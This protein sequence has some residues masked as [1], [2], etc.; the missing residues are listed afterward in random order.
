MSQ[1]L[2]PAEVRR[3]K[4]RPAELQPALQ[5]P[6]F[7]CAPT[8][9]GARSNSPRRKPEAATS[10]AEGNSGP[11]GMAFQEDALS[12]QRVGVISFPLLPSL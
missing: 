2:T 7:R 8:N 4:E 10:V 11:A 3:P 6:R 1:F 9:R 5:A 12:F